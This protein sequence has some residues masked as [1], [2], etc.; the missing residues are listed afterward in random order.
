MVRAPGD[1]GSTLATV[2][3]VCGSPRCNSLATIVNSQPL[4]LLPNGVFNHAFNFSYLLTKL[5]ALRHL[6]LVLEN[7][8]LFTFFICFVTVLKQGA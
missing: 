4:Y 3:V 8:F 7:H 1:L 6:Q 5:N 2:R